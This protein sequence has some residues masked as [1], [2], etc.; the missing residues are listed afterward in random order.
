MVQD[1]ENFQSPLSRI[2]SPSPVRIFDL[3][4]DTKHT[5]QGKNQLC[6]FSDARPPGNLNKKVM[7]PPQTQI[8]KPYKEYVLFIYDANLKKRKP[9]LALN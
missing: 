8:N 1:K 4:N 5:V 6:M 7:S 9:S 3:R 2:L